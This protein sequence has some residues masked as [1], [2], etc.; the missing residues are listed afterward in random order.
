MTARAARPAVPNSSATMCWVRA[1]AVCA[2]CTAGLFGCLVASVA[3]GDETIKPSLV[4]WS[5]FGDAD[6]PPEIGQAGA[7]DPG[8]TRT[9][10]RNIR[11]PRPVLGAVIGAALALSG[12]L[13]QAVMRNPLA[14]PNIV[15]VTAGS[16]LAATI[17]ITSAGASLTGLLPPAGFA[18]ALVAGLAVYGLSWQPGRGTTAVRLVLAGVALTAVLSALTTYIMIVSNQAQQVAS[19][20]AGSLA[21]ANWAHVRMVAPYIL[22]ATVASALLVRPFDLLQL[23]DDSARSLGVRVE[24]TRFAAIAL[25]SLLTGAAVSVSGLIGFVG[26]IVP[27][28]TRAVV[29]PRHGPVMLASACSGALLLV[30]SD[31]A[32]KLTPIVSSLNAPPVGVVTALLGGPYFLF[33]LYRV[34]AI[35]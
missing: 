22:G 9:I 31:L 3:T 25:A 15:G 18:G 1:L 23:G 24:L 32:A 12:V 29:G 33:L 19:W 35:G 14:A 10:V 8:P 30:V 28:M 17:V 6:A 2:L 16:G 26:L 34:R 21:D 4:L 20:M 7:I 27:H 13:L 5:L 11:L